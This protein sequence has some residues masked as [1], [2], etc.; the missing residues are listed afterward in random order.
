MVG[1]ADA[2]DAKSAASTKKRIRTGVAISTTELCAADIRL[3]NAPDRA[4]RVPLTPPAADSVG[5]PALTAALT[6]LARTLGVSEGTLSISL[7]PPLTEVRR[8]ELPPVR[9]D[10][11]QRLI[12]RN[13]TRYF[14]NARGPQIIG[15]SSAAKRVRGAPL[16]VIAAAAS[17]RLIASIRA[18]AQQAGWDV[19]SIAPAETA[20]AG[21]AIA[22]WPQFAK[23]G[24][25]AL[26]AHDDRTDLLQ[27]DQGRLVGVRRF[28]AGA[29]DAA[30]IVDTVGPSAR[31]GIAGSVAMRRELSAALSEQ[32]VAVSTPAGEWAATADRGD[33]LAAH[34]AGS[35]TGPV[36]RADDTMAVEKAR[37]Q[38]FTWTV[39]G[40]AA[41]VLLLA[42]G[43]ELW[44]VHHQ[45]NLVR[46]ERAR[47]HPQI[48]STM[49]GRTSTDAMTRSLTSL[50]AVERA[51]P[52]WSTVLT[53]LSESVP[54]DAY[55]TAIRA[56]QDSL[57]IEGLA[58]H[59]ARV[60]DALSNSKLLTDVKA[61]AGVRR[62]LQ[63]DG[64][65]LD[66]F[67]I[68]ARIVPPTSAPLTT[69]ASNPV[70]APSGR[71]SQ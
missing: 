28:R 26:F 14:V 23:Q 19:E 22:I 16:S 30:M 56:R 59:A 51:S 39:L 40:A 38:K 64:K 9:D 67:Q 3:R 24:A 43:V 6:E 63:E 10:E 69:P 33:V 20:W 31:I 17:I 8:L 15:A 11:L 58:D 70:R 21:A 35:E 2:T 61:P 46:A 47:L 50:Y 12:A 60:F 53:V 57:V 25:Y 18:A 34:F 29:A 27:L 44:G 48:T 68:A 5:W 52:Q 71:P 36:L 45:L 66:H 55:L 7:L 37:T 13:A 1:R 49:L 32:R 65:P 42:A 62:E 54:D 41:A 4:W